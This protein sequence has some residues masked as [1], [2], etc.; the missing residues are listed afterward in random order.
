MQRKWFY[1]ILG[2]GVG[3]PL[4]LLFGTRLASAMA[5][6]PDDVGLRDGQLAPCPE[7]AINCVGSQ[8]D[9]EYAAI[10]P[11]TFT[12]DPAAAREQLQS[13]LAAWPRTT[14]LT[15]DDTYLHYVVRS[16][17]FAFPD[18]LEFQM[19]AGVIHVRSAAR[20]GVGD[21]GANRA[22]IE[23]IRAAWAQETGE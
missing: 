16:R 3:L 6:V 22:R 23:D 20:I 4:L 1:I 2:G 19:G 7:L 14:L 8:S 5:P 10:A 13:L 9:T 11:L 21:L 18:D 17:V 15:A 12:G